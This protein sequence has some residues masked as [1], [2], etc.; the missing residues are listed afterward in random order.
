MSF[1]HGMSSDGK[2]TDHR[3]SVTKVD[4]DR[5]VLE[6]ILT[7]GTTTTQKLAIGADGAASV[8]VT[9]SNVQDAE[10]I[11]A[12]LVSSIDSLI[13]A[14]ATGQKTVTATAAELFAGASV[15]A[16]RRRLMIKNEDP[17]L[18]LRIGSSSVT[19]QSGFAVEPL[20]AVELQFDPGTPVAIYGISEGAALTVSVWEE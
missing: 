4:D 15:R 7:D 19:Q 1:P 13:S 16:N 3:L 17:A 18:R 10:A 11:P 6:A 9:G 14:P 8:K 20:A 12:K 5:G 2:K